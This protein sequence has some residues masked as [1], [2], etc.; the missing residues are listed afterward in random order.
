MILVKSVDF[1]QVVP[2]F[3]LNPLPFWNFYHQL[4]FLTLQK[5]VNMTLSLCVLGM[6]CP[7]H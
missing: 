5:S 2:P 3:V 7:S 1:L 6:S 4:R